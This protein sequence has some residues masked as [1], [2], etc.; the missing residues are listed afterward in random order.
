[1]IPPEPLQPP[2]RGRG[3]PRILRTGER[4]RPRKIYTH[5]AE[6]A[7]YIEDEI[8]LLSE[9]P[10]KQAL[11]SPEADE[12]HDA[13]ILEIKSILRKRTWKLIDR[14]KNSTTIGSRIVLR[15]KFNSDGTLHRRKAR[16]VAQ[17]FSQQ[18][19]LHFNETF[20]PVARQ[21]SIRLVA[22]LSVHLGMKMYHF[23]VETAY[24]NRDLYEEIL[25]EPLKQLAEI[26]RMISEDQNDKE[27]ASKA[28]E[29]RHE[30]QSGD[31]VC[32][33]KKSLYG[34]RQA[35]RN[36]YTK[37]DGILKNLRATP[38]SSDPCLYYLGKGK[39]I[40]IIMVYVDDILIATRDHRQVS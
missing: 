32:L 6:D 24:L 1:M 23:D 5:I 15:N 13:M 27:L 36:W 34:L 40:T 37:L 12:W 9:I 20:A 33:L 11:T 4:G 3:R 31:K 25:M 35:G 30:L 17:G 39:D 38:S 22:A 21:G 16:L 18:P 14:P 26:L 8:A 10:I 29:M 2:S 7:R 19:G 28:D